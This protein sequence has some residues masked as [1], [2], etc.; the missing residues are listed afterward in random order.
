MTEEIIPTEK[1]LSVSISGGF[2]YD[3][4]LIDLG[5]FRTKSFFFMRD[6]TAQIIT[7]TWIRKVSSHEHGSLWQG[8]EAV[9]YRQMRIEQLTNK[10]NRSEKQ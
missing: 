6:G 8:G 4:L 10:Q 9:R 5:P 7:E 3:K 1:I 2:F